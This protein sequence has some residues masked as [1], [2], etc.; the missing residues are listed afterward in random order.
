MSS[1][2]TTVPAACKATIAICTYNRIRTLPRTLD[3]LKLLRGG[4][5]YEVI[6][7]NGPSTDGTTEFLAEQ[8]D[9]RVFSNP[10]T[11]L[12]ISRNIAIANAAGE[13]ISFIDDDA[14]PE[15]DWLEQIVTALDADPSLSAVGGFIRDSDGIDYQARYVRCDA[16]GRGY[17]GESPEYVAL[18]SK[19]IRTFPSLTGT[20]V[21]FRMR[22]LRKVGGFDETY[23]YFYDE[24]DVNKRM[25]D[26]GM[27]AIVLPTAE[28]HHK[29]APSHLRSEKRVPSN[30]YPIA[31]SV[32]YFSIRHGAAEFGWEAA[33]ERLQ[34]FYE[35]EF[36]WKLETL[37]DGH[38]DKPQ[39]ERLM[40]QTAKG[41]L[42]GIESAF[43]AE[44]HISPEQM[45]R[46]MERHATGSPPV[47]RRSR[48]AD[49]GRLRLCMFS[50]DHSARKQGGIGRWTNLVARGLAERG[51]EVTVLG[52]L[53][54]DRPREYADFTEHGYWSHN[55]TNFGREADRERD[56]LGLPPSVA[57][58]AKRYLSEIERIQPRRRFQVASSPIWDVEGA[59]L[60]GAEN[61][62]AVL[63]LHTCTG[64]I[65]PSKPE[66]RENET[67]YKNHVLRVMNAEMQA[68]K[69]TP[70]I[71]ANSKAIMRDISEVY[72]IDLFDRPHAIVAHGLDDIADH[73]S[74]LETRNA[75]QASGAPLRLLFLGRLETRKGIAHL[76]PALRQVLSEFPNVQ[77]D[78]VG[79][80]T[81]QGN[82]V[83]VQNLIAEFPER[84]TWHG[85][86]E[87]TE[88]DT[89]MR[90]ADIFVAPS[91]YESFGLIYVEAARYSLPS[92]G[93]AAGGVPEVVTHGLDGLLAET[94]DTAGL[95]R[96]PARP[97]G[98]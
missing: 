47:L 74:L 64:L 44:G 27:R 92:V 63:S 52:H 61:I 66:W 1:H 43:E 42:S 25:D 35:N 80:R 34:S 55:L 26:A 31:K 30:M 23:A 12:S 7:V 93:F 33:V 14:I 88:L 82:F 2:H 69:R 24:T 46:Q 70:M 67:Y 97:A 45:R 8:N 21:T 4:I 85:F 15:A 81:D 62:P 18:L 65:L 13:Y 73:K 41:I 94:G 56:C 39:F 6:V 28:I 48:D 86:L 87:D 10:E 32:G 22:D 16:L 54:G 76:V 9:L 91:L 89:L 78:L 36:K 29:Y 72:E 38:I 98:E 3:S 68:L 83:L 96:R 51:H 19:G 90:Q 58:P 59:A 95:T 60:I 50:Q 75:A 53:R 79:D 57:N 49:D 11:N 17:Y 71:L 37:A 5:S 20:N 84:V 77:A 40:D